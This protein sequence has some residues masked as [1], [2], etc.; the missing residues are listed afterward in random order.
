MLAK[1]VEPAR[2]VVAVAAFSGLRVGEIRGL[3]WED[4]DGES[5][6]VQR[7]IWRMHVGETKTQGSTA[8]V[9]LIPFLQKILVAHRASPLGNGYIFAGNKMR[10]SLNLDN[11]CA[12]EIRPKLGKAWKGWH[13]FRRGLATNLFE[14]G[15]PPKVAQGIL[16]HSDEAT[17]SRHYIILENR[18]AGDKALRKLEK[19][20]NRATDGQ[21]KAPAKSAKASET[22]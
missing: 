9:P 1:V 4:F 16:R 13:G 18:P 3:R 11:L 2:S 15:V 14:L 19:A 7:S 21:Q 8:T 22:R 17:T 6:H 5:L 12:R 10:F 20:V